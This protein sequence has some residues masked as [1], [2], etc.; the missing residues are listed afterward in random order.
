M[1]SA[2]SFYR[3]LAD[4][5]LLVHFAFVIFVILGGFLV[6]RRR[7]VMPFHLAAVAWAALI[8]FSGWICPLTPLETRLRARSGGGGYQTDFVAHYI[9]P[10]LYPEGLT[11]QSQIALGAAVV[12]INFGIYGWILRYKRWLIRK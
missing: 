9:L 4:L 1:I 6:A 10:M 3:V 8:E 12:I 2:Q 5:V 7:S 11:R